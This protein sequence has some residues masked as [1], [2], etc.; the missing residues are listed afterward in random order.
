MLWSEIRRWAKDKGYHTEKRDSSYFW[1]RLDNPEACGT[2]ASVSKLA[3]A[4][5]NHL[6]NNQF[7]EHQQNYVKPQRL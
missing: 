4:I 1:H 7:I 2:T 6:T 3:L 5:Y